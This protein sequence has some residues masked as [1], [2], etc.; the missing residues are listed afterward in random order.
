M[1]DSCISKVTIAE[2][3]HRVTQYKKII[4]TL[5]ALWADKNFR[6]IDDVLC[7]WTD[8]PEATFLPPYLDPVEWSSTYDV[9]TKTVNPTVGVDSLAG[10]RPLIIVLEKK[11]HIFD[12]NLQKQLLSDYKQKSKTKAQEWSKLTA[13]KNFLMTIIYG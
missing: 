8:L 9:E 4:D 6:C 12:T 10:V 7:T 3:G 11:T 5:P 2:T 13:D 1:K